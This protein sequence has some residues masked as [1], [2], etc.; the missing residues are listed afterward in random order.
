M[1]KKDRWTPLDGHKRHKSRLKTKMSDSPLYMIDWERDLMPEH[2]WIDILRQEHKDLDWP[3]IYNDFL[4]K[5]E[6]CVGEEICLYGMISDF[7]R[8]SE[9]ARQKFLEKYKDFAYHAF[10]KPV[11]TILTLYPEC[12]A[13]WLLLP[14]WKKKEEINFVTELSKLSH[15]LERLIKA[16]DD[17]A[18][19]IKAI[20]LN[21]A[22]NIKR[23]FCEKECQ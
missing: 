17:Y 2:I 10:F 23:Y 21:R 5:L 8:I 22:L 18:G 9:D 12:P 11:G 14:E 3:K 13:K 1:R 6:E 4:D 20:P 19:H 7:G 15:S 16:K